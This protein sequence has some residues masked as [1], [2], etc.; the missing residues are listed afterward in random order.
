MTKKMI[1]FLLSVAI[2]L[3]IV[4]T[5]GAL[6]VAAAEDLT[7]PELV[8]FEILKTDIAAGESF[9]VKI[10]VRESETGL[11]RAMIQFNHVDEYSNGALPIHTDNTLGTPLYSS[12]DNLIEYTFTVSTPSNTLSGDWVIGYL[13]L[14][15]QKGNFSRYCGFK[16]GDSLQ[17]Q[18]PSEG[19]V[20]EGAT[21]IQLTS[22]SGDLARP[23]INSILVKTPVVEKPGVLQLELDVTCSSPF[24]Y[25]QVNFSKNDSADNFVHFVYNATRVGEN[26]LVFEI[27]IEQVRHLG[28]WYVCELYLYDTEGRCGHY[29]AYN[30]HLADFYNPAA[31][32]DMVTFTV[33]GE[34]G[35][36]T[37]PVINAIRVLNNEGIVE[38]P[39]ILKVEFDIVEEGTGVTGME[40]YYERID[41][42]EI[43]FASRTIYQLYA[44]GHDL[45]NFADAYFDAPLK[46]GKHIFEIPVFSTKPAGKY[47]VTVRFL[48]DAA[49]NQYQN[50]DVDAEF[51]VTDE[52]NYVF[53]YGITNQGLLSAIQAMQEG[54]VGRIL[55]SNNKEDNI[56]TKEMLDAIA[57]QKKTLVCYKDGYQWIFEGKKINAKKT[58]DLN[59]TMRIAIISG[60]NLSSGKQAVCLSFENNGDLPGPVQFRFK[61]AF[62][63]EFFGK[64]HLLH[65]FHVEAPESGHETDIDYEHSD[66]KEIPHKDVNFK[67]VMEEKDAWCYVNLHHNSKYV[68]SD[69]PIVKYSASDNSQQ[70][71]TPP[72]TQPPATQPAETEPVTVP[73]V[74]EETAPPTEVMPTTGSEPSVPPTESTPPTEPE[75]SV[76]NTE[77]GKN[78]EE[79]PNHTVIWVVSVLIGLS[80]LAVAGVFVYKKFIKK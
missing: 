24:S 26:G 40:V 19:T 42:N 77:P 14:H 74:T 50:F 30:G 37:K 10:Q 65:L 1:S 67:V 61:T 7:P 58:K 54:E 39:G 73:P 27:P 15:D 60:E 43:D 63:K 71:T 48:E 33:T 52:F 44:K 28:E 32:Y 64:E 35:D 80:V 23:L 69:A 70:N 47:M 18:L 16:Q 45:Y 13:E 4:G 9:Q 17:Q 34:M 6:H 46:T 49:Q 21:H 36:E 2:V 11:S 57:G 72:A 53:E 12:G 51:T 5:C 55:L 22:S 79:K 66:Y 8:S 78:A 75:E 62:V 31:Q 59:L 41:C 3:G 76:P 25:A 20:L 29:H 68:V 56:L 38:K